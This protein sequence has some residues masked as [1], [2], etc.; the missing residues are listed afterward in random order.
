MKKNNYIVLLLFMLTVF[1]ACTQ[2]DRPVLENRI[3]DLKIIVQPG[4]K[5]NTYVLYTNYSN[6]IGYWTLGNGVVVEAANTT[7]AEYPF[8]GNYTVTVSAYGQGGQTNKVSVVIPVVKDNFELIQD[9]VYTLLCG[10]INDPNGKTW[11]A[12]SLLR[13]HIVMWNAGVIPTFGMGDARACAIDVADKGSDMRMGTTLYNDEVTFLLTA[14]D[15]PAFRYNTGDGACLVSNTASNAVYNAFMQTSSWAPIS[16]VQANSLPLPAG[17][18]GAYNGDWQV[19]CTPPKGM[20]WT[21]VKAADGS[22]SVNFPPVSSG[23]GGFL[24]FATDWSSSYQIKSITENRLVVWKKTAIN[25]TTRQI[26]LIKKGTPSGVP[27]LALPE[28]E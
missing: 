20:S 1:I 16:S 15:G 7:V 11:V 12:D 17:I 6:V 25:N 18:T 22:Y 8:A 23:Q 13:G 14:A 26:V 10:A 19:Q 9:H 27:L 28:S 3:I 24:L 21:L 2:E 4:E 5:A